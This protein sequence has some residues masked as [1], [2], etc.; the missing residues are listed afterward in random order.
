[1]PVV[2]GLGYGD[3][4]ASRT[5]EQKGR[6]SAVILGFYSLILLGLA[7]LADRSWLMAWWQLCF[8]PW[9]MK[10]SSI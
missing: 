9:D 1:M 7:V 2:A 4:A 8:H 5:P 10:W 3:L 6:I